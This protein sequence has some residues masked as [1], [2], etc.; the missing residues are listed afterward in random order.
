MINNKLRGIKKSIA[1]IRPVR[2]AYEPPANSIFLSE[3][4]NHQPALLFSQHQQPVT[5]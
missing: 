2:L 1:N 4:T 3:Q 5:N